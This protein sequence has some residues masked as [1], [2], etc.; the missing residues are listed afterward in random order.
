MERNMNLS[1]IFRRTLGHVGLAACATLALGG[2]STAKAQTV[3][4]QDLIT[5][6]G[7]IQQGDKLFSNFNYVASSGF[8]SALDVLVK[9]EVIGGNNGIEFNAA[10]HTNPGQI[11]Q[12]A[13]ITYDVT[14]LSSNLYISDIHLDTD[15]SLI[16]SAGQSLVKLSASDASHSTV[17]PGNHL[18]ESYQTVGNPAILSASADTTQLLK[19]LTIETTILQSADSLNANPSVLHVQE[20]FSQAVPEPGSMA[21]S[22]VGLGLIG[23]VVRRQRA[24]QV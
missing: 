14:V 1:I 4:L 8:P 21:L 18:L 19:K 22:M 7:T 10:W 24:R 5:K 3:T 13:N 6:Q 9:G 2:L 23:A 20:S 17:L 12:V 15:T 16:G 11:P